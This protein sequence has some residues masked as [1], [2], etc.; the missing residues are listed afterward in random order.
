MGDTWRQHHQAN[1]PFFTV[2][3]EEI[4]ADVALTDPVAADG[5]DVEIN[6]YDLAAS[7]GL[8]FF[9]LSTMRAVATQQG[10][11]AMYVE[12]PDGVVALDEDEGFAYASSIGEPRSTNLFEDLRAELLRV[13]ENHPLVS[14]VEVEFFVDDESRLIYNV[15]LTPLEGASRSIFFQY[16]SGGL[17]P[18]I[19]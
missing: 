10:T 13:Y 8:D 17:V 19:D 16:G 18:L 7:T 9:D 4:G 5:S 1:D 6:D 14:D 11:M 15:R 3:T 12:T 2:N